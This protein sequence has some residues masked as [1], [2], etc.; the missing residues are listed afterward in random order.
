MVYVRYNM[1]GFLTNKQF[2]KP[3]L[4]D[5]SKTFTTCYYLYWGLQ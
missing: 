1:M 3:W 2:S 5:Y 4:F